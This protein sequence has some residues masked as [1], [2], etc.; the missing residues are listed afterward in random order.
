MAVRTCIYWVDGVQCKKPVDPSAIGNYCP[1]HQA[2]IAKNNAQ[3]TARAAVH[4]RLAA[5]ESLPV[6]VM[7]K[8][9]GA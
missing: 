2:L 7:N 5:V 6:I 9:K 3:F 8:P 1:E 4:E